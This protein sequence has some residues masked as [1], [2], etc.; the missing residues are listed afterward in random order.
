MDGLPVTV[1]LL[2]P[3]LHE[4]LPDTQELAIKEATVGLDRGGGPLYEAAKTWHEF[5]PM[6]GHPGRAP[7]GDQ[8]RPLRHA[9][10]GP[11]GGGARAGRCRRPP[12]RRDHDPAHGEPRGA[13]PGPLLG[14]GGGG[15]AL[16]AGDGGRG[17]KAGGPSGHDR[18]RLEVLIGTMIETPTRR[19]AGRRDRRGGRLL[20]VR[21]QRPDPDDLRLQPRRRRG[22]DDVGLPREGAPEAEPVRGRRPRRRGRA[23][24]VGRRAGP[25]HPAG[26]Q[27]RRVRRARRR[28]RVDRHLRR[29]RPATT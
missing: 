23:G 28:P 17:K 10:A 19:A 12:D 1:R 25:G 18:G 15:E 24:P 7:R 21:H 16:A 22:P 4:F 27:D 6:L 13:G 26:P 20:L 3:P 29:G 14:G 2:D 8:A 9:G 5:N 11:D